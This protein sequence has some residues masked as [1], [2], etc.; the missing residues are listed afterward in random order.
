MPEE[1][2]GTAAAGRPPRRTLFLSVLA[3]S[4]ALLM[5]LLLGLG[6]WQVQRLFW[7]REL[8]ARVDARVHAP[9]V[10]PPPAA[11]WPQV[12]A[13]TH[14]YLRVRLQ[15]RYLHDKEALVQA[16][17]ALGGGF[18]VITPFAQHDGAI[19]LVNRGFVPPAAR[20]N[21]QR[22]MPAPE[23]EQRVEGLLRISEPKGG[24]LRS[25]DAAGERW[26]SRDVPAIAAARGLPAAQVAPYFV[27]AD[28]TPARASNAWPAGGMTVIRFPDNHLVYAITWYALALMV[29]AGAVYVW[30]H[31]PRGPRRPE[32]DDLP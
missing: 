28:D 3:V 22:G 10:P 24:F 32:D 27:D 30:R 8:I 1:R 17:T 7:K 2:S 19:V 14:E 20:E 5:V 26:F 16:T 25:N 13:A 11:Q 12:N 23:G 4:A 6:S 9:A 31:E 21:G 29:L 15:G 18:W